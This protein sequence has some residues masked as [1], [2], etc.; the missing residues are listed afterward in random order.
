MFSC[1]LLE[2]SSGYITQSDCRHLKASFIRTFFSKYCKLF[3]FTQ[4]LGGG[5]FKLTG[6]LSRR[7]GDLT[8]IPV[9]THTQ[10]AHYS[11][12]PP[13]HHICCNEPMITTDSL[14]LSKVYSL[15]QGHYWYLTFYRFGQNDHEMYSPLQ[16]HTEQ[17]DQPKNILLCFAYSSLSPCSSTLVTAGLLASQLIGFL[18]SPQFCLLHNAVYLESYSM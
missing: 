1:K 10:P 2:P 8:P 4:T 11:R 16:Y 6:K 14:S 7:Y 9:P 5:S 15:Y 12:A 3:F 17:S 18:L 13:K